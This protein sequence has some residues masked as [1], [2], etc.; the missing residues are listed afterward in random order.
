MIKKAAII[1]ICNL[2]C[3]TFCFAQLGT[4]VAMG[5]AL[6]KGV[7]PYTPYAGVRENINLTNGNVSLAIPLLELPGRNG[8]NLNLELQYDSKLWHLDVNY[9]PNNNNITATW[10]SGDSGFS[11]FWPDGWRL[12]IPELSYEATV[13]MQTASCSG[14]AIVRLPDG[15]R[16]S[17]RNDMGC[18][19]PYPPV[20]DSVDTTAMQLDQSNP[21]DVVALLRD[22]TRYH[23][24]I[25]ETKIVDANGNTITYSYA[26]G[27]LAYITD[28]LGRQVTF[29]YLSGT[30]VVTSITYKGTDGTD[31]TIQFLRTGTATM[32]GFFQWPL[33]C[34]RC[35]PSFQVTNAHL[36]PYTLQN[37]FNGIVFPNGQQYSF[38]YN[39]FLELS[40]ITYPSGGYT[41]YDFPPAPDAWTPDQHL[42][43]TITYVMDINADFREIQRRRV[44]PKSSC[45]SAE[46][47]VTT[48]SPS[49]GSGFPNN[50]YM[51]VVDPAGH[52]TVHAFTQGSAPGDL[53]DPPGAAHETSVS[54]YAGSTA[55]SQLLRTASTTY[56]GPYP[57]SL[58]TQITTTEND[59]NPP[60]TKQDNFAYDTYTVLYK[61]WTGAIQSQTRSIDNVTTHLEYDYN[62]ALLRRTENAWLKTNPVNGLNYFDPS[63]RLLGLKAE[64]RVFNTP[65]GGTPVSD[66]QYEYDNYSG[67]NP[68]IASGATQHEGPP[69]PSARGN[70]TKVFQWR[71]TDGAWLATVHQYDD[72]GN[73]RKITDPNLNATSF[74][75]ADSWGDATCAPSSGSAAA[76]RTS[77]TDA[78][79]HTAS[80][81]YNSC[82]GTLASST[83]PNNRTTSYAYN[84]SMGRLTSVIGPPDPNNGNQ[85]SQ[86]I[87]GYVDT[88]SYNSPVT[89]QQDK[90]DANNQTTSWTLIDGLGRV[91]RTAKFNGETDVN[92]WVDDVDTCYDS[93]GRKQYET[94]PYQGPGWGQP[95]TY[96]CPSDPATPAGDSFA[97][98]ALGRLT[99]VTHADGTIV[100]TDYSQ[101]PKITA[102]DE[103]GHARQSQSDVLGRLVKV[104]EPDPAT[105]T[106]FPS[107][108]DY[109]YDALDN[110][111]HV[112]QQG[113]VSDSSQWRTR[114][115]QYDSLSRLLTATNPESGTICYGQWQSGQCVNGYD[116]N[117][118]LL[119]KT[120]PAPNQTGGA[121]LQS[122]FYYDA[123]NRLTAKCF[124]DSTPCESLYY[125][126]ASIWGLTM[127]NPIGRLVA[128]GVS[129]NN[130]NTLTSYDVMGRPEWQ[131]ELRLGA[132]L[133]TFS[134]AYNLDGSLKTITY[135]SGRIVNYTYNIGQRPVSAVDSANNINFATGVHY[136]AAG[137]LSSVVNGNTSSFA[138]ITTTNSYNIRMQPYELK[139]T[140]GGAPVLDLTYDF[141]LG[142][143]DNGNVSWIINNKDSSR[144]QQFGYDALNRLLSAYTPNLN[145][146]GYH[147]WWQGFSYDI[148]GNL[149]ARNVAG[150]DTPL[151]KTVT[152]KNQ[153]DS[154]CYDAA[155]NVVG[156]NNPCLFYTI[157]HTAYENVFDAEN[158]LTQTTTGAGATSYGYDAIGQRVKK[159]NGSTGTFYWQGAS[160]EVL[161]ETDLSGNL[162]NEYIF[163]GG[164]RVARYNVTSGYS[165][166]F[167]DHLGS[168]DVVTDAAGHIQEESDYYPFGGERIVNNSQVIDVINP[169]FESNSSQG[170]TPG[171]WGANS[172]VTNTQ[173]HSGS[174]SLAQSGATTGGSFQDVSGLAPGASYQVSVWVRA[175]AGTSAQMFLWLHDTTGSNAENTAAITPGQSWQQVTLTYVANSTGQL[176][177]HLHYIAGAGTIYY[178]DVQVTALNPSGLPSFANHYK[179]TGKERDPETGCDYFGARYY[180]NPIGRF[181]TPDWA[182]KPTAV[183][184]ANF[185]NP[186]SL[187][188]YS[189]VQNNPTTM[190]DPDG[191]ATAGEI[192]AAID[193]ELSSF[194]STRG[195][196]IYAAT[197]K[198]VFIGWPAGGP[199]E[200]VHTVTGWLQTG[201]A[202]GACTDQC[203]FSQKVD[204]VSHD[205]KEGASLAATLAAPAVGMVPKTSEVPTS[206]PAGPSAR[207]T[208][209]QQQ[210]INEMGEAHGCHTCGA[211]TPG[212]KSG[213]WVGDHQPETALNPPG[214]PQVYKP[215]CLPCRADR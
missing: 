129:S 43:H 190:G 23:F 127:H 114:T 12:N 112:Q 214:N 35:S 33:S 24:G 126:A 164:K 211:E 20:M 150:G 145:S 135:P 99:V 98:D 178:D 51:S 176:R 205:V 42:E 101:F 34:P 153:V 209:A 202:T 196:K 133:K 55:N 104:W 16:Y 167:S 66:T 96:H 62:G 181:I 215:Q 5:S 94:Y 92:R 165:Y 158:R 134:Y 201:N 76:Y 84:D 103:A 113:G 95:G 179:F 13:D 10:R 7:R 31:K 203:N 149:L 48:Y 102:S 70:L 204:A 25:N 74:G 59:V 14:A 137:A 106:T 161:E 53:S 19:H 4:P 11:P 63:I 75:Y 47:Q 143:F 61:N 147:N 37:V 64:T 83:D 21:N 57:W 41:A 100:S 173:A 177:I 87:Y 26:N 193:N 194:E 93:L 58:P 77:V 60:V 210:A 156:P 168:A 125:D 198:V 49:V 54:F 172:V 56:E 132:P 213:N 169:G 118:N 80:N 88:P 30:G 79:S 15:G 69:Q 197:E 192:G 175:D 115:F 163:F 183:P 111:V 186:Q 157:D 45:T 8:L 144:T 105:G 138:G 154:W 124:S 18:P 85:Q 189:Y 119:Y 152:V 151:N 142:Q 121:S 131:V 86:T 22:G 2:L 89:Y 6:D 72:A 184:Y 159:S 3:S 171:Y 122:T 136:T 160:G 71:N 148:W 182:A 146:G 32:S 155:G 73:I 39:N 180:C 207:P 191:H 9:D 50:W 81:K 65:S 29:N 195:G 27:Q 200:Q 140:A 110:L 38:A 120:S 199:L 40:Q 117:G 97:Y 90:I 52:L 170:W 44:C 188:L 174:Y 166:Y 123:L 128:T 67:T 141:G 162:Q 206:I 91:I 36:Q 78:L 17:F 212:T 28:T 109:Q 82:T 185:G 108:T 68:L 130:A 107:E 1:I 187:N 116:G 46:E 208:A 139:T